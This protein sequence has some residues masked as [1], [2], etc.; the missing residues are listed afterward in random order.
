MIN[1]VCVITGASSGIGRA[2]AFE[3]AS[4]Q[5]SLVLAARSNDALNQVKEEVIAKYDVQ[6]EVCVTDVSVEDDCK[7]LIDK[8]VKI[9]GRIDVLINNAGISMR[10]LFANVELWVIKRLMDVNFWGTV[11]CTKYALPHIT[12]MGGSIVGVTSIAGFHGL[13]GRCGYSASKFAMNGFLE[14]IRIEN[15]KSGVHVLIAAP[16]FTSSNVRK[17][18]LTADGSPQGFSPRNEKNMMTSEEVAHKIWRGIKYRKRNII[19][20]IKGKISVL[21]QRILP[22]MLDKLFYNA[23]AKEPDSPIK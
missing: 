15:L 6:I 11:Y 16:S 19:L 5:Y 17:S 22:V 13:P 10:A 12:E 7:I 8:T 21:L 23:M 1:K 3:M 18:A 20:S 4:H 14:T 2:L 9:F